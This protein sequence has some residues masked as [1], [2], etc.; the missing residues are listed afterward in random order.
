VADNL[1]TTRYTDAFYAMLQTAGV[2]PP[3]PGGGG[4]IPPPPP[5]PPPPTADVQPK[6]LLAHWEA[7]Q[8]GSVVIDSTIGIP[9]VKSWVDK[10]NGYVLASP[11]LSQSPIWIPQSTM[12]SQRPCL[13]FD[14]ID[15]F[16][17]FS[18]AL[19]AKMVNLEGLTITFVMSA[20]KASINTL[21]RIAFIQA[22]STGGPRFGY[23]ANGFSS[24]R[25]YHDG[26]SSDTDSY[27]Y[28]TGGAVTYDGWS[29]H[30][31]SRNYLLALAKTFWQG[32]PGI[33]ATLGSPIYSGGVVPGTARIGAGL[34][35]AEPALLF[36]HAIKIYTY[37][38]TD[39]EVDAD[40]VYGNNRVN[41]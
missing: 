8:A 12:V 4:I 20:A 22:G 33:S 24:D 11:S 9:V 40:N 32:V 41:T 2:A 21:Q 30:T 36:V 14:G 38:I 23:S 28:V 6:V 26:V 35:G 3:P 19:K 27:G 34:L 7:D 37:A 31:C 18:A 1:F 15:Q 17:D 13:G 16:L 10:L 29:V 39:A 25:F 5:P